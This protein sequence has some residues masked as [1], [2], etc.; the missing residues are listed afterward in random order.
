[1]KKQVFTLS[2]L[3]IFT[4]AYSQKNIRLAISGAQGVTKHFTELNEHLQVAF[5]P[6][7]ASSTFG[8]DANAGL[9]LIN[10][11]ADDIKGMTHYRYYQTYKGVPV[12]NSMYIAH[13]Q[14]GRLISL[15]GSVVTDF[16]SRL[17][18]RSSSI[19]EKKAIEL[20][21]NYVHAGKY[22][23][24]DADFEQRI[25]FRNGNNA[26]YYPKATKVWYSGDGEINPSNLK[27]AYKVDVYSLKPLDRNGY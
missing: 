27:L 26:T 21:L 16:D 18:A 19:S 13:T 23:W 7:K 10:T 24:Q 2:L 11:G 8:L 22:A 1:M 17:A 12:E 5:N 20:A 25:K 3:L 6:A 14:Q 9:I 15:S 4:C